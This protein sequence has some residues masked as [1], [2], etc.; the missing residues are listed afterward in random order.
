MAGVTSSGFITKTL[1]EIKS[2][3]ETNVKAALGPETNVTA[4]SVLGQLIGIF[5]SLDREEWEALEAVYKAQDPDQATGSSLDAVSAITG[6]IRMPA[7]K[8]TVTASLNLNNGVTVPAG[9]V[10]SVSGNT[11]A[12]FVTLEDVTN[13]S[14]VTAYF[15]ALMESEEYGL[16]VANA[17][18]L[19]VIETP[20]SGWNTI[21]N[22]A[23]ADLGTDIET[24]AELRVRRDENLRAQGRSTFESLRSALLAVE[25]VEE[26]L[27]FENTTLITDVN[28]VPG[29]A[30]EAVVL[31]GA[32]QD[33]VDK[34]FEYKPIGIES[35]G[36]VNGTA[37]DTQG[38][39]H[40]I[41][42]S[43]A[44]ETELFV[45]IDLTRNA[46]TFPVT[47]E[48]DIKTAINALVDA[49]FLIGDDIIVS[50]LYPPVFET[51]G[52]TDVTSILVYNGS[53]LGSESLNEIDFATH[54]DWDTTGGFNDTAGNATYTHGTGVGTLTQTAANQAVAAVGSRFYKFV[55]TVSSST[56]SCTASITTAYADEAASLTLTNGTHNLFFFSADSPANFVISATSTSGGFTLDD[57]SLKIVTTA[58]GNY[59]I[60]D[61]E[62]GLVDVARIGIKIS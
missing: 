32:S 46:A 39:T 48:A 16:V 1:E 21:T 15:D 56:G 26:V 54:T 55:Y 8:S 14:G 59:V 9:S 38:N 25:D 42:F 57:V 4:T 34:I 20:I 47:G 22:A 40:D 2:E 29:K 61:R 7:T 6:T 35:F 24:D 19:T 17:A 43:R 18:T 12:R 49:N 53:T 45:D 28:G 3:L 30:F 52:V 5:A 11:T 41:D 36:A 60:G 58:S 31:G 10:A 13:I 62:I 33:I 51:S 37:T 23:D 50:Q 27:L 44:T